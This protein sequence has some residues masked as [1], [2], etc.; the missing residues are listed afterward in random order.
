MSTTIEPLP[1]LRFEIA[2]A[3]RILRISRA[4]RYER[5]RVGLITTQ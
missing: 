4:T 5:I 2:E 1:H 3:A